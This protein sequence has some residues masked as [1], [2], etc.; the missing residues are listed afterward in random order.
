MHGVSG[1]AVAAVY[2]MRGELPS[3]AEVHALTD[4]YAWLR[5]HP[6]FNGYDVAGSWMRHLLDAYGAMKTR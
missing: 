2:K 3:M 4:F 5:Q 1:V 6:G